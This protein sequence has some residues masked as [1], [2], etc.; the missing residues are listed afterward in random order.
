VKLAEV[1]G[2]QQKIVDIVRGLEDSGQ[3]A[4]PSAE[5]EEEFVA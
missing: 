1:E 5:G 2:L 3:L 4:R